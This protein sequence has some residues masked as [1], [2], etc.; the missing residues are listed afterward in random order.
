[1][2]VSRAATAFSVPRKTLDDKV[3]G[4]VEHGTLPGRSMALT[5]EEEKALC[6]Y[7]IY[8]AE[9]GF[10]LAR[11]MVVAFAW[12]VALCSGNGDRFNPEL[13]PGEHWWINFRKC[14]PEIT[15]RKVDKLERSWA[16][17]VDPEVVRDCFHMLERTL[18][19]NGLMNNPRRLYNCDETFLP[20]DSTREKAVTSKK[21]KSTYAQII[22]TRKHITM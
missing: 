21:F 16:E 6:R 19:E 7:L 2:A 17:C 14:H 15:L 22:G 8:M 11:R 9:R 18:S 1:M 12:A 10:P 20:L 4:R 3:K 13:G 5:E